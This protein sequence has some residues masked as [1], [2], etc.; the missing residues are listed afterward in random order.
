MSQLTSEQI[1]KAHA[2]YAK[3]AEGFRMVQEA[4]EDLIESRIFHGEDHQMQY[5]E[6]ADAIQKM[7]I[8]R[9]DVMKSK[10]YLL[11]AMKNVDAILRKQNPDGGYYGP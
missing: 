7:G 2:A 3:A 11:Q 8:N 1:M 10:G 6:V 4:F 5:A 9:S